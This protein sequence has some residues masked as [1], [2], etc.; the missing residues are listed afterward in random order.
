MGGYKE[1][2]V[3]SIMAQIRKGYVLHIDP[4][5]LLRVYG[6]ITTSVR[7]LPEV[8]GWHYAMCIGVEEDGDA[9]FW[10]I[11]TSQENRWNRPIP[12]EALEGRWGNSGK[13]TYYPINQVWVATREMMIEAH[14]ETSGARVHYY[15]LWVNPRLVNPWPDIPIFFSRHFTPNRVPAPVVP[16]KVIQDPQEKIFVPVENPTPVEPYVAI[17]PVH[18]QALWRT[19]VRSTRVSSGETL[20]GVARSLEIPHFTLH[21]LQ[22]IEVGTA[23]FTRETRDAWAAHFGVEECSMLASIPIK[24]HSVS[25]PLQVPSAPETFPTLT[26]PPQ[27]TPMPDPPQNTARQE[28]PAHILTLVNKTR[29]TDTDVAALDAKIEALVISTLLGD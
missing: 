27:E 1:A 6:D 11:L 3:A 21:V 26:P 28:H 12:P 17:S 14:F 15:H 9:T 29:L 13:T 20:E 19:W 23:L 7:A 22:R 18:A 16:P 25:T 2:Q 4:D 24:D 10:V 8:I 5:Y